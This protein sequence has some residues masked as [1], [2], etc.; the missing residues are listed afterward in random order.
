MLIS[1]DFVKRVA[2]WSA[3]CSPW[4]ALAVICLVTLSSSG[5]R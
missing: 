5:Y 3:G 4:V 1:G 2:E